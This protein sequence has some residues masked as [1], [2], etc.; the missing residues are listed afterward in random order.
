MSSASLALGGVA[1]PEVGADFPFCLF[2]F[3]RGIQTF[4]LGSLF[5]VTYVIR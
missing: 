5:G 1:S 2:A 3:V 4:R